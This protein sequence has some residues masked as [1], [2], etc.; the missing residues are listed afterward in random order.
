M[1]PRLKLLNFQGS[2]ACPSFK[3]VQG[4]AGILRLGSIVERPE[5][6]GNGR[7]LW[8]RGPVTQKPV[9]EAS[10]LNVWVNS[11]EIGGHHEIVV[12]LCCRKEWCEPPLSSGVS[13]QLSHCH[14]VL[15]VYVVRQHLSVRLYK[16]VYLLAGA[17]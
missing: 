11:V 7:C 16:A 6:P 8:D 12:P 5:G 1:E 13:S 2:T 17:W 15:K 9:L 10:Y 4:C 3:D 14:L